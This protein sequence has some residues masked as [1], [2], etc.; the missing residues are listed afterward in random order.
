MRRDEYEQRKQRLETQ[1]REGIALLESAHRQQLRALELV[2]MTTVEE[3]LALGAGPASVR[4]E[5]AALAPEPPSRRTPW[6]IIQDLAV[7]L[8]KVPEVF[9]R[10]RL[11]EALGYEPDRSSLHRIL[12]QL[13]GNGNLKVERPGRGRVPTAYRKTGVDVPLPGM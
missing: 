10:N 7:A 13:V 2:W 3:D 11:H 4:S 5:P 8:P 1:L 6:E 9:D 12:Q